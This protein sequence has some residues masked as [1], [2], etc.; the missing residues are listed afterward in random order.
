MIVSIE[1]FD[2][3]GKRVDGSRRL[4]FRNCK[5]LKKFVPMYMDPDLDYLDKNTELEKNY[6]PEKMSLSD[7]DPGQFSHVKEL[8]MGSGSES[9]PDIV[10]MPK[11]KSRS[12]PDLII[13][14]S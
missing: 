2:K 14:L 12:N 4:T 13:S 1:G 9:N 5:H 8:Q 3:Y 7:P 11:V 6:V 10:T